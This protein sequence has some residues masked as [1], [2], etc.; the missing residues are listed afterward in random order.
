VLFRSE[1]SVYMQAGR[2]AMSG[3]TIALPPQMAQ[4]LTMTV[5]ELATNAAKYGA[6]S[7]PAG[8]VTI[9]WAR[10]G[11]DQFALDWTEA[12]GPAIKAP[13]HQGFGTSLISTMVERQLVGTVA[14]DWRPEGLGCRMVIPVGERG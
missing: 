14:F 11:K 6:L 13:T 12:G 8:R 1:L 5:H 4:S 9:A 7:S 3:P 10:N 2:V